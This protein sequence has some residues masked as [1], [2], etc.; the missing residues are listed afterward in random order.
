[1]R[2]LGKDSRQISTKTLTTSAIE[3]LRRVEGCG[4]RREVIARRDGLA[5]SGG[6]GSIEQ[7]KQRNRSD[8]VAG[9]LQGTS[10]L[11]LCCGFCGTGLEHVAQHEQIDM[12]LSRGEVLKRAFG[13]IE[14]IKGAQE[15]FGRIGGGGPPG[16]ADGGQQLGDFGQEPRHHGLGR[17]VL[18]VGLEPIEATAHGALGGGAKE[19]LELVG[20]SPSGLATGHLFAQSAKGGAQGMK[21]A[22]QMLGMGKHT[23]NGLHIGIPAVRND[24]FGGI[25]E[26]FE[27][28]EEEDAVGRGIRR[29]QGHV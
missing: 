25:P 1:M 26:R 11:A 8:L 20:P 28:Q 24:D 23:G 14:A 2:A 12:L 10:A 18:G 15:A 16:R 22:Q 29:Q 5:Q 9:H 27:L 21:A 3:A 17:A 19:P 4:S 13:A 7:M 6:I